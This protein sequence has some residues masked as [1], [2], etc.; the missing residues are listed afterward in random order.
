MPIFVCLVYKQ[1]HYKAKPPFQIKQGTMFKHDIA[2][3]HHTWEVFAK[4]QDFQWDYPSL[5]GLGISSLSQQQESNVLWNSM[6]FVLLQSSLL[7]S[8]LL[9]WILMWAMTTST[10]LEWNLCWLMMQVQQIL[11]LSRSVLGLVIVVTPRPTIWKKKAKAI[12]QQAA[13]A[14]NKKCSCHPLVL[15]FIN[16]CPAWAFGVCCG[17]QEQCWERMALPFEARNGIAKEQLMVQVFSAN[18]P[19]V[20]LHAF[21][22][23][24][25]EIILLWRYFLLSRWRPTFR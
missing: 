4:A 19:S 16:C 3:V 13:S 25:L 20:A 21:L 8:S 10:T 14:K 23:Q 12:A 15:K 6:P 17:I 7:L 11:V 24:R 9:C 2:R 18:L 22:P 5:S 1:L